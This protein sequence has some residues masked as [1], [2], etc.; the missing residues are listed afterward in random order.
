MARFVLFAKSLCFDAKQQV[1]YPLNSPAQRVA[2]TPL[3]SAMLHRVVNAQGKLVRNQALHVLFQRETSDAPFA[4][5]LTVAITEINRLAQLADAPGP[6]IHH[7]PLIGCV[8]AEQVDVVPVDDD[9]PSLPAA[10]TTPVASPEPLTKP[11]L[12]KKKSWRLRGVLAAALLLNAG[13]ALMARQEFVPTDHEGTRYKSYGQEQQTQ[14]FITE[15]LS[16]DSYVVKDALTRFRALKPHLPDG[17][18]PQLLY[19][20]R[21]RTRVFTSAFLC[22]KP[23]SQKNNECM[24]W[25]VFFQELPDA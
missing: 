11:P 22:A 17:S 10:E 25:M 24:S 14:V 5:R 3:Q 8:L 15:S 21:S 6:L 2:L 4:E 9:A 12:V 16:A 19:I 13:L 18:V 1:L 23:M 20:N 7:V